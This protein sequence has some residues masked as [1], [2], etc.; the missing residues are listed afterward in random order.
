MLEV[1]FWKNS[2]ECYATPN[3]VYCA[4]Q[5]EDKTEE[6]GAGENG[7]GEKMEPS[8][9]V[10]FTC[11]TMLDGGSSWLDPKRKEV[12]FQVTRPYLAKQGRTYQFFIQFGK[13]ILTNFGATSVDLIVHESKVLSVSKRSSLRVKLWVFCRPKFKKK[14]DFK[15][16]NRATLTRLLYHV[17]WN[18]PSILLGYIRSHS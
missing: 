6:N 17:A 10:S 1:C 14:N 15:K 12:V 5:P 9:E 18:T 3:S 16:N 7:V 13:N 4:F 11:I 2:L 8:M